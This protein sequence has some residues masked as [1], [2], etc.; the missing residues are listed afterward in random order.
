MNYAK[1]KDKFL[2]WSPKII[3]ILLGLFFIIFG[4]F[5]DSPGAQG[6]G[7]ISVIITIVIIIRSR[8]K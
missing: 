5:D 4:E 7:L 8:K 2:Y 6:I 1:I 3:A